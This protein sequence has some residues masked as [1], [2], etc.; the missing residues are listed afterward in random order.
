MVWTLEPAPKFRFSAPPNFQPV[1]AGP[2][3][4]I[5]P[6]FLDRRRRIMEALQRYVYLVRAMICVTQQQ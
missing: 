3:A 6:G 4:A 5:L 2:V 1:D